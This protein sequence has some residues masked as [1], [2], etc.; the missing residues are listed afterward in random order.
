MSGECAAS[1]DVLLSDKAR[2][3]ARQLLKDADDRG[4]LV[5][6]AESCTGGLLSTILTGLPGLSHSFECGFV[7]Y[8]DEA[9]TRLL[10]V[11]PALVA[12]C[13]AVSRQVALAMAEQ[14]LE[15]GAADVALAITGFAG[16]GDDSE[17]EE[18]LVHLAVALREQPTRHSEQHFGPLGRDGVRQRALEVGLELL[19]EAIGSVST[20]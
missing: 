17:D 4:M 9:K 3:L 13:G 15:R 19:H 11:P 18:G 7:V 20:G 12:R 8:S 6:T 14:A 16:P 1:L 5:A 2:S 10:G